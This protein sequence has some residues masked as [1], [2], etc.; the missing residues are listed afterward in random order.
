MRHETKD[1]A[2]DVLSLELGKDT[3]ARLRSLFSAIE[4]RK[5]NR[6]YRSLESMCCAW[7]TKELNI[8]QM[9][10]HYDEREK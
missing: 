5:Q 7:L 8:R 3:I 6:R 4:K 10:M 1:A 9:V 2:E